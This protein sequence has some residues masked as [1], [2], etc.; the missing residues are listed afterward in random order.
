MPERSVLDGLAYDLTL[1]TT[2]RLQLEIPFSVLQEELNAQLIVN[3][4]KV[5]NFGGVKFVGEV[6]LGPDSYFIFLGKR[7]TA[8]GSIRFTRDPQNPDLDL[9][10]VYSDY[11]I[12]PRTQVRRQVFVTV[13]ITGTKNKMELGYDLRW[14]EPNG[15]SVASASDVK[16]DVVSFLVLG[17]F[18]KDV[19]GTEGDRSSL[20][21]KSPEVLNQIASSLAS[22]AATEFLSRAGLQEYIK[23]VD[24]A[25]LGTQESRVKLT[26]EIG[27]AIITYDGKINDL[28]SSNMSVDFPLSR[29]LGIPW[30]N[31]MVQISR[32]T[33]NESYESSAQSQQY[34]V[35]E[36]KILQRFAF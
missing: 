9:T 14:D 13:R 19:S 23:R 31:L 22:S 11:Y 36:L 32:K 29:V 1:N 6:T 34:S 3:N 24:I 16:S 26:S 12:D 10:A 20:V 35:W 30:T 21:E 33:L 7:M 2:G 27:R 28:E 25:G 18:T 15:E 8:S 17:V 4:L 5:N